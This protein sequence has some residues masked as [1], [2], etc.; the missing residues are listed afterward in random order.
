MSDAKH[1]PLPWRAVANGHVLGHKNGP[2]SWD[3]LATNPPDFVCDRLT[4]A[5]ATFIEQACNC[6]D[7]LLAACKALRNCPSMS[8]ATL[9]QVE[10]I[11][12]RADVVIAAAEGQ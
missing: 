8:D 12:A 5:N 2:P 3:V 1:T 7:D 11:R 4:E 9:H 10:A 6:F